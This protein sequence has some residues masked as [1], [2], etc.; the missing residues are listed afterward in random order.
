MKAGSI[1]LLFCIVCSVSAESLWISNIEPDHS[2]AIK[3]SSLSNNKLICRAKYNNELFIGEIYDG[4]CRISTNQTVLNINKYEILINKINKFTSYKP[5][6]VVYVPREGNTP[7]DDDEHL[8]FFYSFKY[9]L[10]DL[11]FSRLFDHSNYFYLSYTGK[12]DF[13]TDIFHNTPDSRKSSPVINRLSNPELHYTIQLSPEGTKNGLFS[14]YIDFAFGHESNGQTL[15]VDSYISY[16][17]NTQDGVHYVDYISR[18]WDYLSAE[19]KLEYNKN[20]C[21]DQYLSCLYAHIYLRYFYDYGPLQKGIDDTIFWPSSGNDDAKIEDY[22][23]I[24]LIF[25]KEYPAKPGNPPDKGYWITY[26]TGI[27]NTGEYNTFS[28]NLRHDVHFF[29]LELPV[30]IKYFNGYGKELTTYHERDEEWTIGLQFK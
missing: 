22:D 9:R 26:R 21:Q 7:P 10:S 20:N 19:Y 13:Y 15:D 12:F 5:N 29:G 6:Y 27:N 28:L 25:G 17:D 30:Y 1:I 2:N 14:K 16:R 4:Q 24:R 8:E 18:G 3:T 23:G 11:R